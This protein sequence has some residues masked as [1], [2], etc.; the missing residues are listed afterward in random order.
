[1][2]NPYPETISD[3]G[4]QVKNEQHE[5]WNEGYQA[6]TKEAGK[7]VLDKIASATRR[8]YYMPAKALTTLILEMRKT[9][10]ALIEGEK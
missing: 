3:A 6:G 4:I 10:K 7:K 1:M 2:N 5:I 8:D 9:A